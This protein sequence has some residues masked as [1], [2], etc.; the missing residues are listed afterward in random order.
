M[1]MS[2]KQFAKALLKGSTI[3]CPS[4]EEEISWGKGDVI[5]KDEL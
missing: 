1:D 3:E 2:D 5:N 4:C